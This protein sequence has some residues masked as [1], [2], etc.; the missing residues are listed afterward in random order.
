MPIPLPR[1]DDR[2]FDQLVADALERARATCPDWTD[3]TAGDPG[4]TL[5][6]LFAFLTESLLYRLNRVPPKLQLALLN[7]AGV[8][9]RPPS[10]AVAT[11]TF[12][13][14]QGTPSDTPVTIPA[15]TQVGGRD[16]SVTFVLPNAVTL[17]PGQARADATALH[18]ELI[19][20]ELLAAAPGHAMRVARPPVIAPTLDGLDFLLGVEAAAPPAGTALRTA[21]GKTFELWR[22]VTTFADSGPDEPVFVLDRASGTVQFGSGAAGAPV[23]AGR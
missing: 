16:G 5:V 21:N 14:A 20:A 3:H 2:T 22:E 23:A 4:V 9:L 1:L 15:G 12:A 8:V 7:L 6:E 13:R 11:L 17:D 10:A 19:D 18:C